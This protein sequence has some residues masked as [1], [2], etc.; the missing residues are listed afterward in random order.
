MKLSLTLLAF[1][2]YF[3]LTLAANAEASSATNNGVPGGGVS[4][5]GS[6]SKGNPIMPGTKSK[7]MEI[8]QG[9]VIVTPPPEVPA[10]PPTQ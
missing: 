10:P 2:A 8:N 9:Y 5:P 6:E 7:Q 4:T 1:A 3:A